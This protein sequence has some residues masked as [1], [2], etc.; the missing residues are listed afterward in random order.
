MAE[1]AETGT[2]APQQGL[3]LGADALFSVI[4]TMF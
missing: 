3:K 2:K 4:I 1:T